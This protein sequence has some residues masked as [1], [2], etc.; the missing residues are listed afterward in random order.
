MLHMFLPFDKHFDSGFGAVADSFRYSADALTDNPQGAGLNS[1]LPISFLYRHAIELYLK[2]G[3]ILLHRKFSVPYGETPPDGEPSVMVKQKRQPLYRV[4]S[5]N[6]LYE[7]VRSLFAELAE[8]L[9]HVPTTLP[10]HWFLPKELDEWIASIE[11]TDASSTFFRYP[12]TKDAERDS[13]KS[14]IR[15]DKVE[16]MVER[17]HGDGPAVKAMLMISD[18]GEVVEAYSH[19]DT[20]NKDVIATLR[21]TAEML[22]D[23]HAMMSYTLVGG[24]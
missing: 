22:H 19:D 15:R 3:I 17:M 9:S 7:E 16:S 10:E 2:S 21:Q 4:H 12:V 18:D 24:R 6:P 11:A 1:H 14:T 5:L 8:Q 20:Q 13:E 23:L